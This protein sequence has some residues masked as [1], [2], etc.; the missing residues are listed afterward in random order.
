MG[1]TQV[2]AGM[3]ANGNHLNLERCRHIGLAK[4]HSIIDLITDSA[5][6]AT[7]MACGQ[8]TFNGVL[9]MDTTGQAYRTILE[10]AHANHMKTGLVV[11]STI[12][13]ATPA[14]FYAHQLSRTQYED[15]TL[16]LLRGSV[17]LA[18]GGGRR[19]FQERKDGRDL[20]EE[21]PGLGIHF[22][23]SLR[24]AR[25]QNPPLPL[26]ILPEKGHMPPARK[27]PNA[28]L[29]KATQYAIKR[30][31]EG[32][33]GFFLMVEASQIDWGGHSND[34][35]HIIEEM[36]DFDQ[37]IGQVLDFAEQDG[38]T[39]VIITADHETGGFALEGGEMKL[40]G[41]QS[42]FTTDS[43]TGT[44]VPVFA[45]GPGAEAFMGIYD[46][47][48]IFDKMMEALGLQSRRR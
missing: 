24:L 41:L 4:T 48:H 18:I 46:N 34:A 7:A 12:Q 3:Y 2:S 36:I 20:L 44:M 9:S 15:I 39:L 5:A 23:K 11:T 38:Q 6:G 35:Q 22:S 28:F 10:I 13:H 32:G 43:H 25:V 29:A 30:L 8:K 16:D 1:L 26:F 17:D 21:L 14:A 45:Y 33:E 27:R 19:L 42:K 31:S 40:R 47:T 37:A